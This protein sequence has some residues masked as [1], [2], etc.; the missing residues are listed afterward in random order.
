ME[1]CYHS[2]ML[3]ILGEAIF[4]Y[5]GK[6]MQKKPNYNMLE[7]GKLSINQKECRNL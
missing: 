1:F 4:I 2:E 5:K 3:T 6:C 7:K